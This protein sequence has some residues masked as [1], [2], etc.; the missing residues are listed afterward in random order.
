MSG[1]KAQEQRPA[2]SAPGEDGNW[3]TIQGALAPKSVLDAEKHLSL[4]GTDKDPYIIQLKD[5]FKDLGA[6]SGGR[7]LP[8]LQLG[9]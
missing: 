8:A 9:A 1:V 4:I 6:S 7:P 5:A 3:A 2:S